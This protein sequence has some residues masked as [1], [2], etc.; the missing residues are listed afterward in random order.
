METIPAKYIQ[1]VG[2]NLHLVANKNVNSGAVADLLQTL[3]SLQLQS[4]FGNPTRDAD[5]LIPSSYPTSNDTELYL[6]SKELFITEAVLDRIKSIFGLL[7]TL[8]SIITIIWRW[9][10]TSKYEGFDYYDISDQ[11]KSKSKGPEENLRY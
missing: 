6:I 2:V 9:F 4:K 11:Q 3:Y 1:T 10:K 5:I 7:M 8:A